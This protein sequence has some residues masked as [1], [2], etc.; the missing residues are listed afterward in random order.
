MRNTLLSLCAAILCSI[1]AMAQQSVINGRMEDYKPTDTLSV[2]ISGK[3]SID[4]VTF[5]ADGTFT[6]SENVTKNAEALFFLTGRGG[7]GTDHACIALLAP[8]ATINMTIKL[9]EPDAEGNKTLIATFTG[10]DAAR[11]TYAYQFYNMF[12][13]NHVLAGENLVSAGS[14]AACTKKI[15][16][17]VAPLYATIAQIKDEDFKKQATEALDSRKDVAYFDYAK[18]ATAA[19]TNVEGDTDFMMYVGTINPDDT[20]QITR[21]QSYVEWYVAAHPDAYAPLENSAAQLKHLANYSKN[22]DVRNKIVESF[23]QTIALYTAFGVSASSPNFKDIYEQILEMCT[24]ETY[25][26]FAREQLQKMETTA[27]GSPAMSFTL[28]DPEGN[29]VDFASIANSG[30]VVYIDF[31]ATW[32]GPCKREIPHLA[33]MV[34]SL[35]DNKNIR[36]ISI[37][38][39]EDHDAWKKMVSEDKPAWEQY[40]IPNLET[41]PAVK[42][43]DISTIPRFMIFDKEG[44]LYKSS[45]SRPSDPSTKS[46]LEEL[47]K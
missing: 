35:K 30:A 31:W 4:P 15:E 16:E 17:I 18:Q 25:L 34:E 12:N 9:S 46:L 14:F 23:I 43:Y 47:A 2:Y 27:E 33:T 3:S 1:S 41:S 45:A 24:N 44:K 29:E 19:G 5:N 10:D 38:I 7:K 6:I 13:I 36:I 21:I 37:S 28:Q 40:I 26:N 22:P 32:C 42:G 20:T 11:P 39:D 8:G